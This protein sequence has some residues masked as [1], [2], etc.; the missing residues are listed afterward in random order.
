VAELVDARD[1]K[2]LDG[3]VV[4]VR[5]PPPAPAFARDASE[6][7]H[8]GADRRR[9]ASI[10]ELRLGKPPPGRS[11]SVTKAKT[12]FDKRQCGVKMTDDKDDLFGEDL[13][14][15]LDEFDR[16]TEILSERVYEFAEE[17]EVNDEQLSPLLLRVAL[18][19][20]MVAYASGTAKPSSGG[21]KL[22]LDRFRREIDDLIRA[23]KK[24]ADHFIEQARESIAAAKLDEDEG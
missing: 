24:E 17:E 7:C 12:D 9:R 3:N 23:A 10:G 20:R 1:L 6:G 8:A 16:L 15:A 2:S 19:S 13:N 21:L 22:D 4:W 5:V 11:V 18:S 14:E